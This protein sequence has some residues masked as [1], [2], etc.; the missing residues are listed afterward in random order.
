[1]S[2]TTETKTSAEIVI[3]GQKK[4]IQKLKAGKFYDAQKIIAE[5]FREAANLSTSSKPIE[6]GQTPDIKDMDLGAMVGL[7][8]KF[9]AQVAK[10]VAVC[11][12]MSDEEI[13]KEAYPE[14]ITEAFGTCLELNNV[15][16]N[17]K[18]S[19][20]PIGKLGAPSKQA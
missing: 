19:V 18:N 6:A 11:A 3:G 12:E 17:L 4:T 7:F 9:P 8:E 10:F 20:A 2:E 1:M 16:E 14:E 15:M 5:M 13:L